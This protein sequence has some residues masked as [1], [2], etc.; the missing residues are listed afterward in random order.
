MQPK[1][2]KNVPK[3]LQKMQVLFRKPKKATMGVIQIT[4]QTQMKIFLTEELTIQNP[5]KKKQA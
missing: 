1:M 4:A 2:P 3:K 5:K